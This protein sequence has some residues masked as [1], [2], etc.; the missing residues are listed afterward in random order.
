MTPMRWSSRFRSIS[1]G[2]SMVSRGAK[3][4]QCDSAGVSIF[5][6][7]SVLVGTAWSPDMLITARILQGA[8]AVLMVP[9]VLSVVQL[10]LIQGR[11]LGWPAWCYANARRRRP[12]VRPVRLAATPHRR[13]RRMAADQPGAV[14]APLVHRRSRDQPAGHSHRRLLRAHLQHAAADRSPLQPGTRRAH[15]AVPH[16]RHDHGLGPRASP[17]PS[18]PAAAAPTPGKERSEQK[19]SWLRTYLLPAQGQKD[20]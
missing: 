15:R 20:P 19:R 16:P 6:V 4:L 5:L 18:G 3:D 11:A 8:A 14:Q 1:L 7:A 13:N 17:G 2:S 10:P 9:Q 12:G